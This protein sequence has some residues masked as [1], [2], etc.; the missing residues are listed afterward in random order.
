MLI[1]YFASLVLIRWW[2]SMPWVVESGGLSQV[3]HVCVINNCLLYWQTLQFHI[4]S[5]SGY[6]CDC[7]W[8]NWM[9]SRV[10]W[11]LSH[12]STPVKTITIHS[13]MSECGLTYVGYFCFIY[14]MWTCCAVSAHSTPCPKLHMWLYVIC[15]WLKGLQWWLCSTCLHT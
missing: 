4:L 1:F 3:G 5:F 6:A 11:H 12:W 14:L 10:A 13:K 7:V 15:V 2:S 9:N 8:L